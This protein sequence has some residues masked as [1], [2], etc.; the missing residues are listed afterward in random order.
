MKVAITGQGELVDR[1]LRILQQ[2]VLALLQD[3]DIEEI[4]VGF[5]E[6]TAR[7]GKLAL[8]HL[9]SARL[10][11]RPVLTAVVPHRAADLPAEVR[12]AAELADHVQ[13]L[14]LGEGRVGY[15]RYTM[16]FP[17]LVRDCGQLLIFWSGR[18]TLEPW[19][20]V[21]YAMVHEICYEHVDV[22]GIPIDAPRSGDPAPPAPRKRRT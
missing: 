11:G 22:E 3:E 10:N 16:A 2:K 17:D 19:D 9:R 18:Y 6:E 8:E 1:D 7:C 14:G 21:R 13:E 15:N 20:I 12:H 4:Y 5:T